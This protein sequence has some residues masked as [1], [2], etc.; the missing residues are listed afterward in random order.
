V[1][2]HIFVFMPLH[3]VVP[4]K[5]FPEAYYLSLMETHYMLPGSMVQGTFPELLKDIEKSCKGRGMHVYFD[6]NNVPPVMFDKRFEAPDGVNIRLNFESVVNF[7][8]LDYSVSPDGVFVFRER[9]GD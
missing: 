7:A 3:W 6:T 4:R 1:F 8:N 5:C 9:D 2:A